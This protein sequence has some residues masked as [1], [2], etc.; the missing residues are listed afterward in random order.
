MNQ[1]DIAHIKELL[2]TPKNI[3][4]VTHR[5]PDGDAYGS[6]LALYHSLK[7][8]HNVTVISPNDC[9]EFLKWLPGEDEILI[10]EDDD[11]R[12]KEVLNNAEII[13]TLDF[14]ALHRT[15]DAMASVL[16]KLSPVYIM[17]DHHKQPDN[18]ARYVYSDE[19]ISSTSQMIYHFLEKLGALDR[20]DKTVAT[21]LY[22]GIVTDTASFKYQLA[23]AL[24]HRIVANLLET[25]IDHTE[26][27]NNLYDTNSINR[28]HL[29]GKALRNLRVLREYQTAYITL[30]QS[31]LNSFAYKKG[32]TEGFVN[33]GL[34]LKGVIFAAI[35]IED[36]KQQIIKI[37]F[38]SKGS[39]CVN[40]FARTYFNG[41]GHENAAGGR[42]EES[43]KDTV[44][45]FIK[46]VKLHKDKLH[47]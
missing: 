15:G 2:S 38:R 39:F 44:T 22:A 10:F 26:I 40:E 9:P 41:G 7:D 33:Y 3:T 24:T 42:S 27:Q 43:L 29:L 46:V 21:C 23:N 28:L 45:R 5:N 32:D 31:E 19:M 35:F 30:S 20:I 47:V 18:Y 8:K 37:S 4:I 6:S 11:P 13:F 14:N 12:N 16:E 1:S 34:S 25:G 36:Q 17:I